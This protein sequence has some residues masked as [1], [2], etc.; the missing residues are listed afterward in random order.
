MTDKPAPPGKPPPTPKTPLLRPPAPH[1]NALRQAQTRWQRSIRY[2][3][4]KGGS[5]GGR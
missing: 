2:G 4:D 1:G 5:K 3:W